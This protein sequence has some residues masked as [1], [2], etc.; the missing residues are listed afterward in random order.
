MDKTKPYNTIGPLPT[1]AISMPIISDFV[2]R[3]LPQPL[4][5]VLLGDTKLATDF[6]N[7]FC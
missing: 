6:C 3:Y 1:Q 4:H 5:R 7:S 2:H